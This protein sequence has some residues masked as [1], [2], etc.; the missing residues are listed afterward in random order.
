[1]TE[2]ARARL[3]AVAAAALALTTVGA[4]SLAAPARADGPTTFTSMGPISIPGAGSPDQFGPADPYP[5]NIA[6]S[7]LAGAV[8]NV[9]VA[10][11][12]LSHLFVNDV[13]MLLVAPTGDNLVVMSDVGEATFTVS[14]DDVD[15]TIADG[16]IEFPDAGSLVAGTY[17]PQDVETTVDAY[18]APAPTPG[19][20]TTF[21]GAFSGIDPNGTWRLYVVDDSTGDAGAIAGGWSLTITTTDTAAPTAITASATPNPAST[22]ELLTMTAYVASNGEPVTEG[23]VGFSIPGAVTYPADV[24]D[25]VAT[26][27]F[28]S[29]GREGIDQIQVDYLGTATYLPSATAF[30]L[31]ADD[32]T[33]V[34]G[35]LYCNPPNPAPTQIP[36]VGPARVY[37]LRIFVDDRAG[38]VTDVKVHLNGLEHTSTGDL[39]VMLVSPD[40]DNLMFLSD[41]GGVLADLPD[42]VFSDDGEPLVSLSAGGTFAP[43]NLDNVHDTF[44]AP[45][46][47]PSA[48]A[49]FAEAFAGTSANGTWSLYIVDNAPGDGG[50]L[51]EDWCLELTSGVATQIAL[52]APATVQ[53]GD[54]AVITATVTGDGVPVAAG[55]VAYALDGGAPVE[56]GTP[57]ADGEITFSV[58]GLTR[59]SH[60]ITATFTGAGDLADSVADPATVL[61]ESPTT[62]TLDAPATVAAGT[63]ATV[64]ATVSAADGP[65]TAGTVTYVLDDGTP[66]AAGTPDDGGEVT[67]TLTGFTRG[68]H[69]I[70]ATY[71]GADGWTDSAADPVDVLG[72]EGTT[73]ALDAPATVAVGADLDVVAT[74]AGAGGS[75]V[76]AGSVSYAVDGATPVSAGSP[77]TAGQVTFTLTGL[78]RGTHTID[79]TYTGADGWTTSTAVQVEV[80]AQAATSIVLDAPASVGSGEDV[81]VTAT[82]ASGG[83]PVDAGTVSY[84]VDGG[85]PVAAGTPDADGEVTVTLTGLARG[86]HTIAA[87]YTGADGWT[88]SAA[89]PIELLVVAPTTTAVTVS[90]EAPRA[91]EPLGITATVTGD[92]SA[93]ME[94][95]VRVTVD[96]DV[97]ELDAADLPAWTG[98]HTPTSTA[99]FDI[100]VEY[101]G[102]DTFAPS[103]QTVAIRP[104]AMPTTLVLT[105][106]TTAVD[107]DTV[108]LTADVTAAG[109]GV[110]AA[111]SVTFS[112]GGDVL[113]TVTLLAGT[114]EL[115]TALGAGVQTVVATFVPDDGFGASD[116][117]AELEVAPVVAAGGPYAIAE[118]E[119]ITLSAAGSSTTAVI[120]WDLNGDGDFSD[121][122]G[123]EVTLTWAELEAFGIDDGP[124]TYDVDVRA[125]VDGLGAD[126]TGAIEVS[127]TGPGAIV[128]G[129]RTAVVGE[130]LTLKVSA[131]DSSSADMADLFTYIVDWGDGSPVVE[132]VGPAD[133]PVTHTYTEAGTYEA[134]FAVVDRDGGR[135]GDL[136]VTVE[137]VPAALGLPAEPGEDP[138]AAQPGPPPSTPTLPATGTSD[139]VAPALG[140]AVAMAVAGAL[141]VLT[142]RRLLG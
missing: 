87:A 30:T 10:L 64:T 93:V 116:D 100:T 37:P 33:Q 29:W 31:Q 85:A 80:L 42:L 9:S 2:T 69:T 125:E 7:G 67:F 46:P 105:A 6:V 136:V 20:A 73:I 99:A 112:S 134:T 68:A 70:A 41:V 26:V 103:S 98:S 114:A 72:T 97:S 36:Q 60:S 79:A 104:T 91:H 49:T 14:A 47:A 92:G 101:L 23:T 124:V 111:G 45:A 141:L 19:G 3:A 55:T 43:T 12:G 88:D 63:D 108:T 119:D 117:D 120:G 59:G 28:A 131:D 135:G 86:T 32:D 133:P 118:G 96:G 48:A 90:P 137:A 130:P 139:G 35:D 102:T 122:T 56:A 22:S 107:G 138:T 17:A 95:S 123:A 15:L 13:D 140:L 25:G 4:I 81:T 40:G 106:P 39:D 61:V 109:A 129:A 24:V 5:S 121:A 75:P 18:P 66:V 38:S 1:M 142:R 127:N 82:V 44:P 84:S 54:D 52:E 115:D 76:T 62:L 11:T 77:D 89:D 27:S 65:V 110:V 83:D 34:D 128:D 57:N 58:P 16:G 53:L 94:G 21:A 8:S 132:V 51:F 126:A 71:T 113:G 74:I 78:A 50:R